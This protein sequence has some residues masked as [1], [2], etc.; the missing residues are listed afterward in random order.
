MY[1][2]TLV[3]SIYDPIGNYW[4]SVMDEMLDKFRIDLTQLYK[5]NSVDSV[6]TTPTPVTPS[7]LSAVTIPP[8][9]SSQSLVDLFKRSIKRDFSA[10][11][12]LMDKKNNDQWH[13]TFT[14]MAQAQ[15]LSDVL[16]P[17]YEFHT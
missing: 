14:N 16:N 5:F 9:L 11:P 8:A 12:T 13:R 4:L 2:T 10:C 3:Y 17:K 15:D 7:P 6:H 1:I